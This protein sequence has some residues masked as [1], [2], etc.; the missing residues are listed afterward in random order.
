MQSAIEDIIVSA[1]VTGTPASWIKRSLHEAGYTID[2]L[3]QKPV[4][5]YDSNQAK[6]VRWSQTFAAGQGVG[7]SK[8]VESTAAVVDRLAEQYFAAVARFTAVTRSS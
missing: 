7:T 1:A 4:R 6:P 2:E 5:L 3:S 8:A